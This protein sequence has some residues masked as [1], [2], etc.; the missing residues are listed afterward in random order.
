MR[1]KLPFDI[2]WEGTFNYS[3][4]NTESESFT[5]AMLAANNYQA[6]TTN[7]SSNSSRIYTRTSVQRSI[8]LFNLLRL[9]LHTGIQYETTKKTGNTINFTGLPND[10]ILGP[11]GHGTSSGT[12]TA[13]ENQSTF[14]VLFNPDIGI[15]TKGL[16]TEKYVITPSLRPE[17]ASIYGSKTKWIVS[18]A[19]GFRWN[20][21]MEDFMKK[22]EYISSMALRATW[23]RVVKYSASRYDVWGVYNISPDY[24]YNGEP[25]I[26]IDYAKLPSAFL[27]PVTNTNWNFGWESGFLNGKIRNELEFY[28]SQIDHQ[29]RDV[30]LPNHSGFTSVRSAETSLV[31]YGTEFSTTVRPLPTQSAIDLTCNLNF[32]IN[33]NFIAKLPNEARQILNSN[34]N[35]ANRLGTNTTSMLLYINKGV[36][37]TDEDVPVD[38]A[39][40]KRLRVGG[41]TSSEAYFKAGDPVWVDVNGDYI[42][43]EKDRVIAGDA[44]SRAT[45]GFWFKVS[46]KNFSFHTS[47]NFVIGRDVINTVL[48]D[49]FDAYTNPVLRTTAQL[50]SGAA[51]A[52][53]EKY[54]FWTEDNRY[55]ATYPNPYDYIHAQVI[56]PFRPDQTLFL[57]DG[58]YFKISG[59]SMAYRCPK[60]VL[61]ILGCRSMSFKF[62][63][64]NIITLSNYSGISPESVNG[65]GRDTS[66]GYPNK[67]SWTTGVVIGL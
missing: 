17:M 24:T 63:V 47:T 35:V 16:G 65:L 18:P 66:G 6:L 30:T 10:Y 31:N 33:R 20:M 36:Y 67:R 37:A 2:N 64:S 41:N 48:A 34:A 19:L 21:A 55:N 45:G 38:P 57:E 8:V 54:N 43:D 32:A 49:R 56:D 28:Y 7:G 9:G 60:R 44:S 12:A 29:L 50:Q 15:Q 53:I 3:F 22:Y 61:A 51:I 46:Y 1:Y 26:P 11:I 59:I 40:G 13:T 25:Y 14:S 58:S 23:G 52:P 27:Q 42:I 62:S 5:P 4:G 39:T